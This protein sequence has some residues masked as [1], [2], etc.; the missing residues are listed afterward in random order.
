MNSETYIREKNILELIYLE[1]GKIRIYF[2]QSSH[3]GPLR[4]RICAEIAQGKVERIVERIKE[5]L[6]RFNNF[7]TDPEHFK[8][9]KRSCHLLYD[10]LFS[11]EIK[12]ALQKTSLKHLELK[13][14]DHLMYIPW[15]WLFDGEQFLCEQ[16]AIGR[17]IQTEVDKK[18]SVYN[19]QSLKPPLSMLIITDPT[20]DLAMAQREGEE[21]QKLL[22][23][24]GQDLELGF[25]SG[26]QVDTDFVQ[27]YLRDYN[28]V[29][30]AGHIIYEP[31]QPE[32]SCWILSD[33]R[34]NCRDIE[35]MAGGQKAMPALVFCNACKS[36][37]SGQKP[38][39]LNGGLVES[40]LKA[41]V[42]FYIGTFCDTSDEYGMYMG[43]GFY[44][45][46]MTGHTVAEALRKA[47][48]SFQK[49]YGKESLSWLN[50][51][52]YGDPTSYLINNTPRDKGS[53]SEKKDSRDRPPIIINKEPVI[54]RRPVKVSRKV[55]ALK[56]FLIAIIILMC[57]GGLY[58]I[59][60][61]GGL[62]GRKGDN[63]GVSLTQEQRIEILKDRIRKMLLQR[64]QGGIAS[65][66]DISSRPFVLVVFNIFDEKKD[67]APG[68]AAAM[69]QDLTRKIS[70]RFVKDPQIELGERKAL[71]KLLEEMDLDLSVLPWTNPEASSLFG[72]FL[73]ARAMLFL[74]IC[75]EPEGTFLYS[76]LVDVETGLVKYA[77][78]DLKL[79]KRAPVHD[80]AEKVYLRT[81]TVIND[82]YL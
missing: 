31:D 45:H 2:Y 1:T 43:K 50:Y 8:N 60:G 30:Y 35:K 37:V 54:T 52:L 12:E 42:Q 23:A 9:L 41:G 15:E 4:N 62:L 3:T 20:E 47:R 63:R 26:D 5:D 78:D 25:Y 16:F 17:Q 53:R 64:T 38:R 36:A 73:Y 29:H 82:I 76:R 22:G 56:P 68:W 40:F 80:L 49:S 48:S 13:L 10:E 33:G 21:I 72:K 74:D 77:D 32:K 61:K 57:L 58:Y 75:R 39:F 11:R 18:N 6:D 44:Y 66:P 27:K 71:D 55:S 14:D 24:N 51:V 19:S 34:F 79:I 65:G 70:I 81:Q 69:L 7:K 59:M 67:A 46:L 28:L